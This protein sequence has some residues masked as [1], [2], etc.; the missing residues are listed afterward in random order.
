MTLP[1]GELGLDVK[2]DGSQQERGLD[3]EDGDDH[4]GQSQLQG[5]E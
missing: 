3:D 5:A 1:G 2:T 4:G